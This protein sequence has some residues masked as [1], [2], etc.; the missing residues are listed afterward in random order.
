MTTDE[1]KPIGFEEWYEKSG[2]CLLSHNPRQNQKYGWNAR[3]PELDQRDERIRELEEMVKDLFYLDED[4]EV[5]FN[6]T[7][8]AELTYEKELIQIVKP[9]K[10]G[11][12]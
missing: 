8:F 6:F 11:D 1:N 10:K 2:S 5:R 9:K 3:Q 7:T 4:G 12:S